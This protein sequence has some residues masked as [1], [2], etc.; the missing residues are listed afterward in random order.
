MNIAI[1]V[2]ELNWPQRNWQRPVYQYGLQQ[3]KHTF[4]QT[5]DRFFKL[6]KFF[7]IEKNSEHVN[8]LISIVFS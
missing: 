1:A 4:S 7:I 2:T 6:P 8:Q 5:I 3:F